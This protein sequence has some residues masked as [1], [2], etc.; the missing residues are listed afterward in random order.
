MTMTYPQRVEQARQEL[1]GLEADAQE[2]ARLRDERAASI[3]EMRAAN[4]RDFARMAE[5]EGQRAALVTMLSDQEAEIQKA[6]QSVSAL[7]QEAERDVK[8][9]RLGDIAQEV[10]QVRA[11]LYAKY[12]ALAQRL[13][14]ELL[15]LLALDGRWFILRGQFKDAARELGADVSSH[16]AHTDKV[17]ALYDELRARGVDVDM[18]TLTRFYM[19][20][21]VVGGH[22]ESIIE[23]GEVDALSDF[24]DRMPYVLSTLYGTAWSAWVSANT[25]KQHREGS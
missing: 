3:E 14:P 21:E 13:E 20:E 15:E 19:T 8:L 2:L 1:A 22:R 23:S 10:A 5:L 9:T 17:N 16:W 11:G 7:E 4:S 12:R 25:A 24:H 18:L 6:R